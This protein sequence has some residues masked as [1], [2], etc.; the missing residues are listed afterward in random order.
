MKSGQIFKTT[1][2]LNSEEKEEFFNN[3]PPNW[4][5]EE[6]RELILMMLKELEKHGED[7]TGT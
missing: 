1:A 5:I 6:M 4:L 7:L 2:N 3:L